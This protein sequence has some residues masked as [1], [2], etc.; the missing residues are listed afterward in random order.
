MSAQRSRIKQ[1]IY[2]KNLENENKIL[3]AKINSISFKNQQ[4]FMEN[5][6]VKDEIEQIKVILD[7]FISAGHGPHCQ[8]KEYYYN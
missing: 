5:N 6:S 2:Y 7:Q 3:E 8:I 4:L 1:K